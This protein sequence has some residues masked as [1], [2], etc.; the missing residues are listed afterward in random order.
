M[1][2]RFVA[3]PKILAENVTVPRRG[4]KKKSKSFFAECWPPRDTRVRS[5]LK[6]SNGDGL[7]SSCVHPIRSAEH[8]DQQFLAGQPDHRKALLGQQ[9]QNQLCVAPVMFLLAGLRS[10]NRERQ[11]VYSAR[12]VADLVMTSSGS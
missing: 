11:K 10:S 4:F 8:A 1:A 7:R 12:R 5:S 3:R 9:P 2:G 6:S